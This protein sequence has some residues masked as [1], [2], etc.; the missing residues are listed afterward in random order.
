[1]HIALSKIGKSVV[2]EKAIEFLSMKVAGSSGDA[3][4]FLEI[5]SRSI[6]GL[7]EG[8]NA[9]MLNARHEK[10]LLKVP[11]VMKTFKASTIKC[12]DLVEGAPANEKTVLCVCVHLS[13]IITNRP[14]PLT[15]LLEICKEAYE[16][17]EL[18]TVS[19]MK[20]IVERLLDSGL[21]KLHGGRILANDR[22]RFEPQ[23]ED[24]EAA[25]EE[26]LLKTSYYEKM[27]QKLQGMNVNRWN[28]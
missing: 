4:K 11:H 8:M 22:I 24:V 6:S 7:M 9:E 16:V 15:I 1:M 12:R 25:V 10:P 3:R 13:N 2:V 20:S 19:E 5:L 17:F 26:V 18:E 28:F 21:I 14:L 27:V 23:L